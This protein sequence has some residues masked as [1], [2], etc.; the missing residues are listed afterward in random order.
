MKIIKY[1]DLRKK[2]LSKTGREYHP[3]YFALVSDDKDHVHFS[4]LVNFPFI[5]EDRKLIEAVAEVRYIKDEE[6]A[7]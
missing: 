3:S 7:K 1:V 6:E 5:A 2:K 4:F